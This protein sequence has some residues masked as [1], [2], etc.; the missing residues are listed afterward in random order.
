VEDLAGLAAVVNVDLAQGNLADD[1]FGF[2]P[3]SSDG[4]T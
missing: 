3:L 4:R 2:I 1:G